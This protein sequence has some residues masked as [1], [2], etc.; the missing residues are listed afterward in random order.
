MMT[1][2]LPA[3]TPAAIDPAESLRPTFEFDCSN[4]FFLSYIYTDHKPDVCQVNAQKR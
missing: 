3:L 1:E 2:D 4:V